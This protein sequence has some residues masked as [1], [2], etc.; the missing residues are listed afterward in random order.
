MINSVLEWLDAFEFSHSSTEFIMVMESAR[1]G[2]PT[3]LPFT[4]FRVWLEKGKFFSEGAV[5]CCS[6]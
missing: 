4:Y 5:G 2:L 1:V 6:S 3:R